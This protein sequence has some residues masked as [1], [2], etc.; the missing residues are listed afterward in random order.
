MKKLIIL[1]LFIANNV[2]AQTT[3]QIGNTTENASVYPDAA[4]YFKSKLLFSPF[5]NDTS[6]FTVSNTGGV[7]KVVPIRASTFRG[8]TGPW[9]QDAGSTNY[10][11]GVVTIGGDFAPSTPSGSMTLGAYPTGGYNYIQSYG[12]RPLYLN[13]I[14]NNTILSNDVFSNYIFAGKSTSNSE[15]KLQIKNNKFTQ[16]SLEST[17]YPNGRLFSGVVATG[18]GS[19]LSQNSFYVGG[20]TYEP[21]DNHSG[22]LHFDEVGNTVFY[23]T[24]G[25]TPGVSYTPTE[26]FKIGVNGSLTAPSLAGTGN[27]ILQAS[28]TGVI[29]R[30]TIDPANLATTLDQAYN[31]FGATPSKI[32]VD[33]A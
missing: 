14:G 11:A 7:W 5:T 12:G 24:N 6:I 16:F 18:Y 4:S 3:V 25:L 15:A 30:T 20:G 22:I 33:A 28:S 29:Q 27:A 13:P 21:S 8:N 9:S 26:R 2:F 23:N 32:N 10:S 19:F 31:N 17:F 1:I